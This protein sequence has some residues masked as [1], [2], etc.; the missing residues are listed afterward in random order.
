METDFSS[1]FCVADMNISTALDQCLKELALPEVFIQRVKQI[2]LVDKPGFLGLRPV[3]KLEESR[4][5]LYRILV[6]PIYMSGIM[7]RII[8]A[9]D[10][11]I[12]GRGCILSQQISQYRDTPLS[13]DTEKLE[14]LCGKTKKQA[15]EDHTLISCIVPRGSADTLTEAVLELGVCVPVVFFGS[16]VGLRDKLGLLRITVPVEKEIIWF[17]V[18]HSDAHLVEKTIIPLA[19]LDVPGKGFLYKFSVHAPV[20]NLGIRHGKRIHAATMEQVIAVLD[21]VRGS[22]DWRRLGAR[23]PG[24]G[25]SGKRNSRG[26]FFIGEEDETEIFRRT[27]MESGA[28]G[29]TLNTLEMRPYCGESHEQTMESR[30]RSLCDIIISRDI[31]GKLLENVF[32]T[33]LF[34]SGKSCVLKIFNVEITSTKRYQE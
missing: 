18:P 8:E 13:F 33:G 16:G 2:S 27:A 10:L 15:I 5:L 6:P 19:R 34:N 7:Q 23:L 30:S 17:I 22:S 11:K 24:A 29:A 4:A 9:T 26:L 3:T 31:E 14:R 1:I 28:K 12:G 20:V 21:E 32:K 25:S